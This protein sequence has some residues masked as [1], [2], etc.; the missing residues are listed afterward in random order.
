MMHSFMKLAPGFEWFIKKPLRLAVLY[1]M[2]SRALKNK[3]RVC[4]MSKWEY[5]KF[6]LKH[7]QKNQI[8]RVL[9]DLETGQE[10]AAFV[11]RTGRKD[12]ETG[13][14]EF[15][16]M[17]N[18]YIDI[19]MVRNKG[20]RAADGPLTG[21]KR[22]QSIEKNRYIYKKEI[23]KE[24]PEKNDS[25]TLSEK[26][27]ETPLQS[28]EKVSP[29]WERAYKAAAECGIQL[30]EVGIGFK[31]LEEQFDA[32]AILNKVVIASCWLVDKKPKEK[33]LT[34][35]RLRM[36]L[37]NTPGNSNGK[38]TVQSRKQTEVHAT[39]LPVNVVEKL[40]STVDVNAPKIEV[41][42]TYLRFR[43]LTLDAINYAK[44]QLN[45]EI[46]ELG[47]SPIFL[48]TMLKDVDL[49]CFTHNDLVGCCTKTIKESVDVYV[50][51]RVKVGRVKF[52]LSRYAKHLKALAAIRSGVSAT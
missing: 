25:E 20:E 38:W 29:L 42:E 31:K 50:K 32:N 40:Q 39:H 8:E 26:N 9:R 21:H 28:S 17:D 49:Q 24:S 41:E 37:E 13:A 22:A 34:T 43:D 5:K 14:S 10:R 7:S 27:L 23:Y 30:V 6:G 33:K 15:Q 51:E 35:A 47:I 36:F 45:V 52:E 4:F 1:E 18:E 2:A 11:Q 19:S 12:S 48:K 44:A 3:D 46:E 16:L